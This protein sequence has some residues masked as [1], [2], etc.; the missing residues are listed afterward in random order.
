MTRPTLATAGLALLASC[1]TGCATHGVIVST[2]RTSRGPLMTSA[3]L[4][5]V[6]RARL[7]Q[8]YEDGADHARRVAEARARLDANYE[9]GRAEWLAGDLDAAATTF[10]RALGDVLAQ[11]IDLELEPELLARVEVV[12]ASIHEM[13]VNE[14]A[15]D[16]AP[17]VDEALRTAA[18]PGCFVPEHVG[19]F[20]IPVVCHPAVD[21]MVSFYSTRV[22]ER[23]ELGVRR[24]G[25]YA[26]TVKRILEEE[27]V[28][29]DIA[30]LALVESN[31]NV[32]A[33]SRARAKGLWQ[34]IPSTGRAYHLKQ[35][36]WVDERADFEKATRSSAQYLKY[37]HG[38]FG[39]WYLALAA[40][41][42]GEGKIGRAIRATGQKDFWAL[43]NT[44]HIR[45][46]TKDYVPAFLAVNTIVRDPA[47]YG[48]NFAPA[49]PLSWEVATV[50]SCTDLS[51]LAECAGSTTEAL[52]ELNPELRRG[53]TPGGDTKYALRVP[54]GTALRFAEK[55]AALP[56]DQRLK[57][58]HHVVQTGETL[59][60]IAATYGT[61]VPSI[62]AANGLKSA[63]RIGVGWSLVIPSGGSTGIP[64]SALLAGHQDFPDTSRASSGSHRTRHSYRVRPGDTL[65]KIARRYGVSIATLCETNGLRNSNRISVGQRLTVYGSRSAA[66]SSSSS[67][68]ASAQSGSQVHVVRRGDTLFEIATRYRVTVG[69]LRA[70][71]GLSSRG[72]IR[73][74]QR[75]KVRRGSGSASNTGIEGTSA[76]PSQDA[77]AQLPELPA[78]TASDVVS[79]RP[80]HSGEPTSFSFD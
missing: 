71:N 5:G 34:F 19:A 64:A 26:P 21:A 70:W 14:A 58:Q 43:R 36:F 41:N 33:H 62:M 69:Q 53:T 40:Y 67:Q 32:Q 12:M 13:A 78:A 72:I 29:Q 59:N 74:G 7:A 55:Y 44:R 4:D 63:N 60:K 2:G 17:L 65:G 54:T 15:T 47:K 76:A 1:L 39:D 45:R 80:A 28:P 37:L 6:S 66:S 16:E 79:T 8:R 35:D 49:D 11:D 25:K 50:T 73:P 23:F 20:T 27:G 10:D 31:Y 57:W 42:A 24:Y 51:V 52:I 75:I 18:L 56:A 3:S 68:A 48:M 30:W 22:K 38:M 61:T 46:E 9:E 77:V